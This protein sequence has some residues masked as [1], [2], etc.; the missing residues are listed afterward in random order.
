MW[1]VHKEYLQQIHE[2]K[3]DIKFLRGYGSSLRD[4]T[5]TRTDRRLAYVTVHSTDK[6]VTLN[7]RSSQQLTMSYK[8]KE[9]F[10]SGER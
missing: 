2:T 8:Q 5:R 10:I 1:T 4:A 3:Y 9:S 6:M 7:H